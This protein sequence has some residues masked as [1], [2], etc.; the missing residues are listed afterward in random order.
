MSIPAG[1]AALV[2]WPQND[3]RCA[4]TA[5]VRANAFGKSWDGE[6]GPP[7][8]N[9]IRQACTGARPAPW[10]YMLLG[11][12]GEPLGWGRSTP[13]RAMLVAVSN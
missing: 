2:V 10:P 8:P 12:E 13:K 1:K 4:T 11:F 6:K 7:A 5:T 3:G 9:A